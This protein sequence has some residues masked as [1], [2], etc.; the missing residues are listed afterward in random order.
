MQTLLLN[1]ACHEE[2]TL[3]IISRE[4]AMAG[5]SKYL[6]TQRLFNW[7]LNQVLT[8]LIIMQIGGDGIN[9]VK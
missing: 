4:I 9:G 7:C 3:A 8:N 5:F 2:G 6:D 1:I